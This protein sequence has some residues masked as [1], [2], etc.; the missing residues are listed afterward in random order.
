VLAFG[1]FQVIDGCVVSLNAQSA[2]TLTV[3]FAP[4]ATGKETGSIQITDSEGSQNVSLS[5]IG[6]APPTDTL[7]PT[8]LTFPATQVGQSAPTQTVVVTN[9]GGAALTQLSVHA[10]GTG[11]GESNNCGS[12]LVAQSTCTITV[13][14][15][16]SSVGTASGQI[17]VADSIRS[18][19]VALTASGVTPTD[20]SLTPLSLNFGGQIIATASAPQTITLSNN[21]QTTLSGIQIQSSNP[22]FMFTKTCGATLAAG[23]SCAIQVEFEPHSGG[24]ESGTL[25]EADSTRTQ[26][27]TLTG[28]GYLPNIS[29]TPGSL[30]F[31]VMG[32][33]MS[34]AAQ[35]LAL[36][37]GS[38]GTLTGISLAVSGAFAESNSCGTSLGPEATCTISVLFLPAAAGSQNGTL[39]FSSTD[40]ALMTAQLTGTGIGFQLL[41]TSP[42]SQTVNSGDAASYSLELTPV[43]GSAG[44]AAISCTN[45]P[46]NSTCTVS[47]EN[48]SLDIPSNIQVAVATGVGSAS[49]VHR[50]SMLG[51]LPWPIGLAILITT[52][53]G[54]RH[55][56][57]GLQVSA[58]RLLF[59]IV[60]I[61]LIGSMA[62]CGKGGGLL[63][64]GTPNP[65]PGNSTTPPGV[66]T[67]T[68]SA[69]A[70]GL[71]KSVSLTVQVQ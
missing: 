27:V 25:T 6:T 20:D 35:T 43:N 44:T 10:V 33:Q 63:G 23:A 15:Q 61:G 18:Q 39:T 3:Q 40:S 50:A 4:H 54:I 41:P 69:A 51:W 56:R 48:A 34:S 17:V 22:D 60:L 7:S 29:L 12:T 28:I 47:P 55:R 31:G 66:Y 32:L 65:L 8:S 71:N 46:P 16:A 62:A 37:N 45:L 52:L 57:S 30:N 11:F 42:T 9:S 19:I 36:S 64:A 2:C 49:Q 14:F 70:G 5:G 67:F 59:M 53:N 24:T 26:H 68:V 38:T 58:H 1:D 21:I 13:S